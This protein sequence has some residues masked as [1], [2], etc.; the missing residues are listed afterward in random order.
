VV[1]YLEARPASGKIAIPERAQRLPHPL[2]GFT[3]RTVGKVPPVG[4]RASADQLEP[5]EV[6]DNEISS[7]RTESIRIAAP[8]DTDDQPEATLATGRNAGKSIFDHHGPFAIDTEADGGFEIARR[9]RLARQPHG[10]RYLP[11]DPDVDQPVEASSREYLRT[12][13]AG[14]DDSDGHTGRTEYLDQPNRAREGPGSFDTKHGP[15]PLV[16][17]DGHRPLA[18]EPGSVAR[19]SLGKSNVAIVEYVAHPIEASLAIDEEAVVIFRKG[20]RPV[21]RSRRDLLEQLVEHSRPRRLV[22]AGRIGE[23][24]IQVKE[25]GVYLAEL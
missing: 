21:S 5:T 22:Q 10:C 12:V 13:S 19:I 8:V 18:A 1:G 3:G 20:R 25:N 15:E 14:R 7:G 2:A 11:V 24:A 16:F 4:E 23:H 17:Q 9:I 6:V